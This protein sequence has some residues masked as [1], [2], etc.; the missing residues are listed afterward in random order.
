MPRLCPTGTLPDPIS[1]RRYNCT[2]SQPTISPPNEEAIRTPS[3]LFP[4]PVGPTT[5]TMWGRLVT[6]GP[7]SNRP[8]CALDI[9][10]VIT[11]QCS[12]TVQVR[13]A[14]VPQPGRLPHDVSLCSR[15]SATESESR[16]TPQA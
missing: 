7:I 16:Q 14:I 9:A 4:D 8:C 5:A 15:L 11:S 12:R 13:L 2:E 1:K 3:S 10:T 6:C